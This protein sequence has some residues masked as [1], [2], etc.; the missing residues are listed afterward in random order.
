MSRFDRTTHVTALQF[1]WRP[2][3][4]ARSCYIF[5]N[6]PGKYGEL[7]A[8]TAAQCSAAGL[9]SSLLRRCGPGE[10]QSPICLLGLFDLCRAPVNTS[11]TTALHRGTGARSPTPVVRRCAMLAALISTWV[12]KLLYNV[13]ILCS[14]YISSRHWTFAMGHIRRVFPTRPAL[15]LSLTLCIRSFALVA[16]E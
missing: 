4:S 8:G 5:I 10:L 13:T 16:L 9:N 3:T 11:R 2:W 14:V 6:N 1:S 15:S 12:S 7:D